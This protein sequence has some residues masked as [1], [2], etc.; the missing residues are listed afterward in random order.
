MIRACSTNGEKDECMQ[1]IGGKPR[2]KDTA[3]K[4]KTQMGGNNI[5]VYLRE[6]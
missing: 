5:K 2:R 4:T 1:V 6:E 3:R